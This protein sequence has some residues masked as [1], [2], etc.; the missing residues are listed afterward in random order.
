MENGICIIL[1]ICHWIILWLSFGNPIG[2]DDGIKL[3]TN[4]G[5]YDGNALWS[6]DGIK[7]SSIVGNSNCN[8]LG[9]GDWII[10]WTIT[11]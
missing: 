5:L 11:W 3:G 9:I 6:S 8:I 7:L 4:D 1:G 2:I 10:Y